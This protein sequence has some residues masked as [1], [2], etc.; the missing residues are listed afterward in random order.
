MQMQTQNAKKEKIETT[1]SCSLGSTRAVSLYRT[2]RGNGPSFLMELGDF[3]LL[4]A[5][6]K[7]IFQVEGDDSISLATGFRLPIA[8]AF[9]HPV[10]KRR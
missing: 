10:K 1:C 3:A 7:K 9:L 5:K 2:L 6:P 8:T 4:G